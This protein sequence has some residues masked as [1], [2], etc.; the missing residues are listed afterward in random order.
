MNT[1]IQAVNFEMANKLEQHIE[2]KLK[3]FEKS[4]DDSTLVEIKMKVVKPE[5]NMN[6]ETQVKFVALGSEFF[7]SKTADT[8]EEGIDDTLDA[9]ARQM[10]KFKEK[11]A[12]K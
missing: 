11:R 3:K 2:K 6:K 10:E 12:G 8:F 4:L 5:T 1:R 7:A 9:V